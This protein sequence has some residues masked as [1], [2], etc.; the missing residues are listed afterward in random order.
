MAHSR[1]GE[2][3]INIEQDTLKVPDNASRRGDRI[4]VENGVSGDSRISFLGMLFGENG[5]SPCISCLEILMLTSVVGLG[6]NAIPPLF[7]PHMR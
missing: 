3:I 5:T 1:D 7:S 6:R 4:K 2:S